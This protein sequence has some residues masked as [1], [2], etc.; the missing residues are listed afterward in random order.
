MCIIAVKPA[1][2]KMPAVKTIETMWTNNSDGAGYMYPASGSVQIR[3]GFMS[4]GGLK[5]ELKD[6]SKE[7][8][9]TA[10]PVIMHFRI[11]T[12]GGNI[13]ECTHPFPISEHPAILK[14]L[15]NHSKLAACHNGMI[16]GLRGQAGISDTMEYIMTQLAPLCKI[17]PDFWR[18][19]D[20]KE[21]IKTATQSKWALM[22]RKGHIETIGDFTEDKGILYSN[23]SY[24]TRTYYPM[25][26]LSMTAKGKKQ[27]PTARADFVCE[28]PPDGYVTLPDGGMDDPA[29]YWID[30]YG[31]IYCQPDY[32][33]DV[34]IETDVIYHSDS[35]KD[36][37]DPDKAYIMDIL[38]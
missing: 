27:L 35:T 17:V 13:P 22:D 32:T 9:T 31:R 20:G 7:V 12:A 4:L 19:P 5:A 2:V 24:K 6:L 26:D 33:D 28:L 34:L 11:G 30:R 16:P 38:L 29:F 25:W 23:T 18:R 14:K 15:H 1:G 36:P 37:Y 3:K 8:D 21:I 10:T